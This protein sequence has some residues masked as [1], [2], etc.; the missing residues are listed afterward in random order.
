MISEQVTSILKKEVNNESKEIEKDTLTSNRLKNTYSSK[1]DEKK[2]MVW[3]NYLKLMLKLKAYEVYFFSFL[4]LFF[5]FWALS[6]M[7][8]L[9]AK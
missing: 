2:E 1:L 9:S 7:Y 6:W 5:S 3:I 4:F 8:S